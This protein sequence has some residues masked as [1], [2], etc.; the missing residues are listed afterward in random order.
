MMSE[1]AQYTPNEKAKRWRM[2]LG[3][4]DSFSNVS[5]SHEEGIMDAALSALYDA[6]QSNQGGQKSAGKQKSFPNVAKWIGDVRNHFPNDV[7]SVMQADAIHRKGLTQLILEPEAL[8]QVTPDISM[9]GTLMSLSGQIPERSK[10]TARLLV[11]AVVEDIVKRMEQDIRKAVTGALNKKK[12]SPIKNS[13]A[14]DWKRTINANLK[15]YNPDLMR[16]VPEKFYFYERTQQQKKWSIILDIDQSGSMA[17]SVIY[18]SVMGSIFASM[19]TLDTKV[20]VFDTEVTDVSEVC[21]QDPVDLLFGIQ[22]GGGTDINK[23]VQ[24]CQS[25][26]TAPDKTIFIL[27]SDLY[28]GGVRKGLLKQLETMKANGVICITLLALNDSGKPDYDV[29]L[30][31]EISKLGI[32]CFACTPNKLPELIEA[33]LKGKDLKVFE[34]QQK[35]S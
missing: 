29:A 32:A 1:I 18:A 13:S 28:E 10:A 14:I 25:L 6:P 16:I 21:K 22:L 2:I 8:E 5:L 12:H 26:I 15:N 3:E 31:Q 34:Q 19:P 23:S 17:D 30:A 4:T 33:A 7:V 24:Y 27:I 20:V 35:V 11:K 9:V